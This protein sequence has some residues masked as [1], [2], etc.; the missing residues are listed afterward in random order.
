MG[1]DVLLLFFN[2]SAYHFNPRAHAGRDVAALDDEIAVV[3]SIHAPA[4]GATMHRFI[5]VDGIFYFNP[6]A[7]VGRDDPIVLWQ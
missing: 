2:S 4:W 1:R 6:R 7:R 3:I 5:L